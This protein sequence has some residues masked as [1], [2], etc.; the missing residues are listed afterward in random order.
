MWRGGLQGSE[1]TWALAFVVPYIAVFFAFVVYPVVFGL[2]MG[3][4]PT[5]YAELFDDPIY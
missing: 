5:L 3:S 2:W 4:D 1:Y